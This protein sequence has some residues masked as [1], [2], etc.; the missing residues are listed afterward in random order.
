MAG[1]PN[2]SDTATT[3]SST[4]TTKSAKNPFHMEQELQRVE[5]ASKRKEFRSSTSSTTTK[6]AQNINRLEQMLKKHEAYEAGE[7]AKAGAK[8]GEQA[9]LTPRIVT[10]LADIVNPPS[11]QD[12]KKAEAASK[13]KQHARLTPPARQYRS[14]ASLGEVGDHVKALPFI[15]DDPKKWPEGLERIEQR[16]IPMLRNRKTG[17]P[18]HVIRLGIMKGKKTSSVRNYITD[19]ILR[20]QK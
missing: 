8:A 17:K 4:T 9:S 6:S 19:N 20:R 1:F 3:T 11:E 16:G 13:R 18:T 12:Q 14:S 7:Q 15:D 10:T 5:A 2:R